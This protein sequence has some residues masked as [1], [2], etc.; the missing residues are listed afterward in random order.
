MDN[1]YSSHTVT[2]LTVHI[3]V[4]E[5]YLKHLKVSVNDTTDFELE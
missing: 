4:V 5:E 1:R 3:V 2:R